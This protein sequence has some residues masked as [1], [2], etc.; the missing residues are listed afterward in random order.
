M[1]ALTVEARAADGPAPN[2]AAPAADHLW[3]AF[4]E[5]ARHDST[6]A[7][8]R[9]DRPQLLARYVA[10]SPYGRDRL[11]SRMLAGEPS[12]LSGFPLPARGVARDLA[13]ERAATAMID[14][15]AARRSPATYRIAAGPRKRQFLTLRE[16]ALKWR[17]GREPLG[18]TDLHIRNT[19]MEEIIDPDELSAFNILRRA[20]AAARTQEM[21]SFVISS[22]GFVTDS[23]SDD[24]DSSN[25]CF[26]GRKLWLSWDTYE[27]LE[28]G[29]EDVER[30]AVAG[31]A[32][33]DIATWLSLPTARWF[34]VGPGE[35]LFLPAN[36]THKVITL[37]PYVGVG[38]FF[39]ALPN[40][41]RLLGHWLNRGP[42]WSKKDAT[43]RNDQLVGDIAQATRQ[44]ILALRGAG[45]GDRLRWGYDHL[46]RSAEEFIARCPTDCFQ[47]LWSDPR[48]RMVAETIR[49]PWPL[50]SSHPLRFE[51]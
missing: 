11:F 17:V 34:L 33:F 39:I 19:R 23:H 24:P 25:Y 14:W 18:I 7:V 36:L 41:L 42:L 37:E 1:S 29:L 35:T 40:C 20:T 6:V 46:E 16:F 50:P 45:R 22:R 21:F 13:P 8:S 31:M 12:V 30:I 32:R 4:D 10:P 15:L 51:L 48:F 38:G 27:G 49:A 28:H 43:G 47:A 3:A 2:P 9:R 26:T 44:T 5:A